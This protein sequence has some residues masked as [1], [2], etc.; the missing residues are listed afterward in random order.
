MVKSPS[1]RAPACRPIPLFRTFL[2]L[3]VRYVYCASDNCYELLGVKRTSVPFAIKRA[4]RRLAAEWHPDKN[5][6]P[7]A[8]E[9]FTKYANA[10]EVRAGPRLET[11]NVQRESMAP[12]PPTTMCCVPSA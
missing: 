7:R 2:A 11:A 6:D 1:P 12:L 10:Y 4:Y 8:K 5:P 9:I 3:S